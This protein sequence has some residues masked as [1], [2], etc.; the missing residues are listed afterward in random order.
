M[1]KI[2][3]IVPIYNVEKYLRQCL[4]SITDQTYKNLEIILVNDGSPDHCGEICEEY[5]KKDDR[6]RVIH[7]ENKGLS[8]ARNAGLDV[9]TGSYITFLDSD[10]YMRPD[11]LEKLYTKLLKSG[12]DMSVCGIQYVDEAG[13]VLSQEEYL[14]I[15]TTA[16]H[17]EC[18]VAPAK[19]YKRQIFESIRFPE[20]KLC[21]DEFVFHKIVHECKTIRG[22]SERMMFYRQ[23]GASITGQKNK[24]KELDYIE[25]CF[26]RLEFYKKEKNFFMI[27]DTVLRLIACVE[28]YQF[29]F[30][31]SCKTYKQL[32]KKCICDMD[33]RYLSQKGK[34][35]VWLY[36]HD[37]FPYRMIHKLL[38]IREKRK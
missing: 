30:G 24:K 16:G 29:T 5:R 13:T 22:I 1:E 17:T 3:V 25:S 7:Q 35:T 27:E 9:A 20:G 38:L 10:D 32:L 34:L 26:N 37:L 6:I 4:E 15:Y 2:S 11:M 23:H 8:M 12:S 21:E 36:R 28:R 31:E 19:L 33:K 18:V 14:K